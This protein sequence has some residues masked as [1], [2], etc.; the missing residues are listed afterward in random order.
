M[1]KRPTVPVQGSPGT[2]AHLWVTF[3]SPPALLRMHQTEGGYRC[4]RLPRPAAFLLPDA[5]GGATATADGGGSPGAAAW[6]A[7]EAL[8]AY[9]CRSAARTG[10]APLDPACLVLFGGALRRVRPRLLYPTPSPPPPP[11]HCPAPALS[12]IP[13]TP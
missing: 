8:L 6:P 11:A 1:S 9:V 13:H 5:D 10:P 2:V 12:R 4:A 3:L 7:E